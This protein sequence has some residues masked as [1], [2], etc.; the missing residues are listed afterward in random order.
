MVQDAINERSRTVSTE[1][2]LDQQ[3]A[4]RVDMVRGMQERISALEE[5]IEIIKEELRELLE[6]K[7][8]SWSDDE[9]YAR[10]V[11][12]GIRRSYDQKA[13]DELI[14]NDPLRY[15]WLKDYRKESI[16][17]GGVQIK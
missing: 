11:S 9:G 5:R 1:E 13:L 8:S 16:V 4:E 14:I 12:E 3:I 10:L 7:G 2:T 6:Q 17:R 15:G